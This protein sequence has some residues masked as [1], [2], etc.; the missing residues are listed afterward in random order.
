LNL[1]KPTTSV[2]AAHSSHADASNH[3]NYSSQR[4]QPGH[5]SSHLSL[6]QS[7]L[8]DATASVG[9]IRK[10]GMAGPPKPVVP[11]I[12]LDLIWPDE[13]ICR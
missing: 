6:L 1:T 2:S 8:R 7:S 13:T 12:V 9:G 5:H 10:M 3:H 11:D 4:L